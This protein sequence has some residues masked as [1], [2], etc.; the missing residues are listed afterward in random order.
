MD[1]GGLF[2]TAK[3]DPL[4]FTKRKIG[5]TIVIDQV[6]KAP[7]LLDAI[8]IHVDEF[9]ERGQYL[10][11]GSSSLEFT[12]QSADFPGREKAYGPATDFD[13]WRDQRKQTVISQQCLPS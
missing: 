1:D 8:K 9:T 13:V 3:D 5:E 10:L 6:Q 12:R 2:E 7:E 4:E 11:T